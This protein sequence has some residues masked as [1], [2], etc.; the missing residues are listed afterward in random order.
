MCVREYV[1][2]NNRVERVKIEKE[3]KTKSERCQ[4]ESQRERYSNHLCV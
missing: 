1:R 2:E 3:R 4:F